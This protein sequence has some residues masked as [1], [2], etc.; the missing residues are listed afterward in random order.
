MHKLLSTLESQQTPPV[1]TNELTIEFM[2][3]QYDLKQYVIWEHYKFWFRSLQNPWDKKLLLLQCK[4]HPH[5]I[6]PRMQVL[7]YLHS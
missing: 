2:E 6:L 5:E 7:V 1:Q 4:G 3:S